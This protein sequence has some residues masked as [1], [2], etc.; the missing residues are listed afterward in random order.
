VSDFGLDFSMAFEIL[1]PR[2]TAQLA[3]HQASMQTEA[4]A[5]MQR[6][7]AQAKGEA[8]ESPVNGIASP[9]ES[10]NSPTADS[11]DVLMNGTSDHDELTLST[12]RS[13]SRFRND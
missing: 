6:R 11:S 13:V 3:Q 5:H 2:L 7:L 12:S 9:M 10:P 4:K 1:R 8:S